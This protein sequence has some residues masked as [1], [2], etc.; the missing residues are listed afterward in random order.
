MRPVK[1]VMRDDKLRVLTKTSNNQRRVSCSCC[2]CLCD[3]LECRS[4]T[5]S[6]RA[7][8]FPTKKGGAEDALETIQID[9]GGSVVEVPMTYH[10]EVGALSTAG[11]PSAFMFERQISPGLSAG[12]WTGWMKRP[13]CLRFVC[14]E[15]AGEG[16]NAS[17]ACERLTCGPSLNESDLTA[18]LFSLIGAKDDN[19][20]LLD[21][22]SAAGLYVYCFEFF[23]WLRP[24]WNEVRNITNSVPRDDAYRVYSIFYNPN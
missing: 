3:R 9:I 1:T 8:L 12:L 6:F 7:G 16:E 23:G 21:N 14:R 19:P 13:F 10:G 17:V 20:D 22:E 5:G 11:K 24:K 15:V 2:G 4:L 18:N